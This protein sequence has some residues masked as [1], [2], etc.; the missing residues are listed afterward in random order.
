MKEVQEGCEDDRNNSNSKSDFAD[1]ERILN[2]EDMRYDYMPNKYLRY[3]KEE[4]KLWR[5]FFE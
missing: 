1:Y 3:F 2:D 4:F 5:D